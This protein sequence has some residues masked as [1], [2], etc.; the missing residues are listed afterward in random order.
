MAKGL[1]PDHI[2]GN[3]RRGNCLVCLSLA[4]PYPVYVQAV[5]PEPVSLVFK[6]VT[7]GVVGEPVQCVDEVG[8]AGP[9]QTLLSENALV[10][11]CEPVLL[12]VMPGSRV[13]EA[14]SVG[15]ESAPKVINSLRTGCV[16]MTV[17]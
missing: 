5:K 9:N 3:E 13:F 10:E 2:S 8:P 7:C 1:R 11:V 17:W 16:L 12:K 14:N 6:L 15:V 4:T